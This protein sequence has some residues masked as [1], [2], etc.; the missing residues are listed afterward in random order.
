MDTPSIPH[1][2]GDPDVM[3][4]ALIEEI[5]KILPGLSLDPLHA[6]QDNTLRT[7]SVEALGRQADRHK[8]LALIYRRLAVRRGAR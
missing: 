2:P 1:Y 4:A 7:A 5:A 3:E 8:Q 6:Y